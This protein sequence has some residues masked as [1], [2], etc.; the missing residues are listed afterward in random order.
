MKRLM[1][2]P[3]NTWMAIVAIVLCALFYGQFAVAQE[4]GT[5]TNLPLPRFVSLKATEGYARRGP[6]KTHRIDWVFQHRSMPLEITAEFGHWRRVRD[7]EGAG[8][9]MHYSLISGVRT[10]LIQAPLVDLRVNP[11][12]AAMI[13][14]QA[15]A[16]VV[17]RLGKCLQDW[18]R[19]T[20]GAEKGWAPKS[21]L[22][23]VGADELRD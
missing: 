14:A 11:D 1:V 5:E 4:R 15:E 7:R 21:A 10:V 9:W 2:K 22:W 8:G 13:V 20:A 23:G 3:K 12:P 17:A 18:C 19:I 6:S 16:G